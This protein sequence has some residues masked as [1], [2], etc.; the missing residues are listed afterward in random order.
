MLY[1]HNWYLAIFINDTIR[2][3]SGNSWLRKVSLWRLRDRMRYIPKISQ[4]GRVYKSL[5][6]IL[7]PTIEGSNP[8]WAEPEVTQLLWKGKYHCTA[9]Y[10]FYFFG[11][12]FF[13]YVEWTMDLLVWSN[14]NL[15]NRRS[16]VQCD[17]SLYKVFSGTTFKFQMRD[18]YSGHEH[19]T[20]I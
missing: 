12:S 11:F 19:N 16:A 3:S 6:M 4:K 17:T 18:C 5:P 7:N 1:V 20:A 13:A 8:G 9:V 15:S 2:L 14:P 10:L